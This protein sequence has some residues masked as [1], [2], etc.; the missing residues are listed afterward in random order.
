MTRAATGAAALVL[1]LLVGYVFFGSLD[2]HRVAF[3]VGR[4]IGLGQT[5][6]GTVNFAI[7]SHAEAVFSAI[8]PISR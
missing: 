3:S 5:V 2:E 6:S 4:D 1:F 8:W 7:Y